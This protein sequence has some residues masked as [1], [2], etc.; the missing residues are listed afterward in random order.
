MVEQ[1][2]VVTLDMMTWNILNTWK[3]IDFELYRSAKVTSPHSP[4]IYTSQMFA[5]VSSCH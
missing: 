3:I 1:L 2:N 5:N 4:V